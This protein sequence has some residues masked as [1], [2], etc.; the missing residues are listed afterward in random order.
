MT[1]TVP[2]GFY[3][4]LIFDSIITC[5]GLSKAPCAPK[6][7]SLVSIQKKCFPSF[8]WKLPMSGKLTD[9]QTLNSFS[10]SFKYSFQLPLTNKY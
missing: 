6:E 3:S 7:K 1:L 4:V 2:L 10:G 9:L 5:T 8:K